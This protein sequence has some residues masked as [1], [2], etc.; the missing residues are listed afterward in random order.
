MVR[1]PLFVRRRKYPRL[2]GT[3]GAVG[4][5][6]GAVVVRSPSDPGRPAGYMMHQC[7]HP[8]HGQVSTLTLLPACNAGCCACVGRARDLRIYV[9]ASSAPVSL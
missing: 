7:N 9:A 5:A 4:R 3:G 1:L 2:A 8:S 6:R